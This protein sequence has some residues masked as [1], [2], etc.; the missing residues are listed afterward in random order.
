MRS[1]IRIVAADGRR[2][3]PA[4]T[5]IRLGSAAQVCRSA[6]SGKVRS[7]VLVCVCSVATGSRCVAQVVR[8]ETVAL[9]GPML[10]EVSTA[11]TR[12]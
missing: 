7:C 12:K 10:P 11:R 6:P 5:L 2:L 9:K 8:A 3:L 4:S 1:D